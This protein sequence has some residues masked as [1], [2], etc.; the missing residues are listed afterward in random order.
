M[1]A[2]EAFRRRSYVSEVA[3]AVIAGC[4]PQGYEFALRRIARLIA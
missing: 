1:H 3:S 4:G 2:R